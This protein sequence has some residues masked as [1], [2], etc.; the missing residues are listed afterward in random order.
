M[1]TLYG[2][3][4]DRDVRK[5][6]FWQAAACREAKQDPQIVETLADD[7]QADGQALRRKIWFWQAAACREA[8]QI[9]VQEGFT[10][11][12]RSWLPA[13]IDAIR[14]NLVERND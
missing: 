13:L 7:L 3:P 10:L 6:W 12:P 2:Q 5:I 4:I 9:T 14:P 1:S 11:D 8:K